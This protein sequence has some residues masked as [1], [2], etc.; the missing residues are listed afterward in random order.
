MSDKGT[1]KRGRGAPTK[2]KHEYCSAVIE[3]MKHGKS[4]AAFAAQV[5]VGREVVWKWRKKYV[6]FDNACRLGIEASQAW[7]ELL[8]TAVAS[9]AASEHKT[10]KRANSGMVMFMMSRR[11]PDYYA[12]NRNIIEED[13]SKEAEDDGVRLLAREDRHRLID[14]YKKMIEELEGADYYD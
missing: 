6:D 5:G 7:W 14:K 13:K 12:K 8:A 11:F 1:N 9:G 4:L 2:Y 3:C 10:Y